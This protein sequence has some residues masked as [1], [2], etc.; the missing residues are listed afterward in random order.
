MDI[1]T[2]K[3]LIHKAEVAEKDRE[4]GLGMGGS[5][6]SKHNSG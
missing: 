1:A 2:A 5:Y 6:H 3:K 4:L